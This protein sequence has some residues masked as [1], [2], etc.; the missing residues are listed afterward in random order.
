VVKEMENRYQIFAQEG[1]RNFEAF[2]N[3][4]R[5]RKAEAVAARVEAGAMRRST[6]QGRCR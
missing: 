4:N 2:N 3:R 6:A 1:C 5:K